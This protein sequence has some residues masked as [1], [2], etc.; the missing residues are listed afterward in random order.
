MYHTSLIK[1]RKG[2]IFKESYFLRTAFYLGIKELHKLA[3]LDES[4]TLCKSMRPK[5]INISKEKIS[6]V[7][8]VVRQ[9][10]ENPFGIY[11][12]QEKLVNISSGVALDD[13]IVASLL[14]MLDV[15]KSRMEDFRQ[16]R[17]IYKETLF[18]TSI[19]KNNYKSFPPVIPK[20][21]IT[22]KYGSAKV[23]KVNR[24]ILRALNYYN[25]RIGKTVDFKK[26]LLYSL[27]AALL[28]ICNPNGSRRHTG[29]SKLKYILLQD[30][31]DHTKEGPQSLQEYAVVVN[32]IAL[33]N[34]IL[35]KSST[36]A[37]LAQL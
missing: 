35:N 11:V 37:E 22:K 2:D 8:E 26:T 9:E 32:M 34:T 21:R 16:K 24:N 3:R 7:T 15:G 36:Y 33:I 23:A 18:H 29:K 1:S 20:I 19:K 6:Q 13:N 27:S 4:V 5:Q 28:S 31:E 14:N 25:L 10:Y 12:N 30:L 17:L